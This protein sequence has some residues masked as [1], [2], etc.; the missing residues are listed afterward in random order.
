MITGSFKKTI[1]SVGDF[2]LLILVL[3]VVLII[4]G[5]LFI[6]RLVRKIFSRPKP[7]EKTNE[8]RLFDLMENYFGCVVK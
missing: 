2:L 3:P 7:K 4:Q 5:Y 6:E 8:E 1:D